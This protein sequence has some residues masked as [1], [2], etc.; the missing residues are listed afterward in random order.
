MAGTP[1]AGADKANTVKTRTNQ[2]ETAQGLELTTQRG[3]TAG[4]TDCIMR[5]P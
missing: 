5:E 2:T 3:R 1:N 4:S